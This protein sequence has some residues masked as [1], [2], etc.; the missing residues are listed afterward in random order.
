MGVHAGEAT[1]QRRRLV[2]LR[3]EPGGAGHG[4]RARRP[5]RVHG[6]GRPSR[7]AIGLGSSISVSTG[8]ATCSRRCTCSR[9][10]VPGRAAR[11]SRRCGRSTRTARTLP[12]ELSSFVGR[13]E[14]L[15]SLARPDALVAGRV[16]RRR[17]RRGQD[18]ARAAGRLG[19]AARISPTACGCA[20]SRRC[21]IPTT[22]PTP[23]P[24]RSATCHRRA[25]RSRTAC[26]A[27]SSARSCCS[28]STTASTSWTRS[29]SSCA[30]TTAHAGAGVG[31]RHEP[32]GARACAA[33]TSSRWRRSALPT[34]VGP[35]VGAGVGSG[36]TVRRPRRRG[37]WRVRGRRRRTA[38]RVHDL[39]V[40]LDG[41][42]LAIEL[43]AAQTKMMTPAE[44]LG[45]PRPAV[46]PAHG[47]SPHPPRAP[48]D[49]AGRDR[50]VLRPAHRRRAGAARPPVGVRRWLRPRRARSRS[51]LGIGADE[52][53]AFELLASLVAKSLVER[54]ERDGVTRYRLLEMIRQYAART[55]HR[56]GRVPARPPATTTP[57]TT[58][59][60]R[61]ARHR[62]RDPG[63]LRRARPARHRD[64]EHRRCGTVAARHRPRRRA[65]RVLR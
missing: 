53:D 54:N 37:A 22:C 2:R 25:C 13:D 7:Y 38:S 1:E 24:P 18:A 65:P 29:P 6:R 47:R 10:T 40:R 43:A 34:G 8:C 41:I 60:G 11:R 30:A 19:A 58:C 44:I 4:G 49:P 15:R 28:S 9:S 31:P 62:R 39:C 26:P 56:D 55:A 33:S 42:P 63:G 20:S 27:S 50:L 64:R 21:S 57:A 17:R 12:Y 51:P 59:V 5:D 23:S 52:F 14:E 16:D 45:P 61:R 32:R 3:R 46:P 35:G 48:P 36:C